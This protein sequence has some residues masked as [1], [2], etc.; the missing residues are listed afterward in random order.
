[1]SIT[2]I[3][4]VGARGKIDAQA[5]DGTSFDDLHRVVPV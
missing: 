4:E 3:E 5:E 2:R 1:M